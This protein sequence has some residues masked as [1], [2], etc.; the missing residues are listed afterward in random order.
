MRRLPGS[1]ASRW[2]AGDDPVGEPA[3]W[4]DVESADGEDSVDREESVD[5]EGAGREER[6]GVDARPSLLGAAVPVDTGVG[7]ADCAMRK[8]PYAGITRTGS[9][10]GDPGPDAQP[11][12]QPPEVEAPAVRSTEPTTRHGPPSR[13]PAPAVPP[14]VALDHRPGRSRDRDRDRTTRRADRTRPHPALPPALRR[15]PGQ[16]PGS[17]P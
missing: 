1:S 7:R 16:A 4:A 5:G 8:A 13:F 15:T 3:G 6:D 2:F 12:S 11:P 17:A 9:A 10:V 14:R